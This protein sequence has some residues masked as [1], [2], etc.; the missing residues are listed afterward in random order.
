MRGCKFKISGAGTRKKGL[1]REIGEKM[2]EKMGGEMGGK[3]GGKMGEEKCEG[4]RETATHRIRSPR[5]NAQREE[6]NLL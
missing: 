3:M 6:N 2:G 5:Q 4:E 1:T